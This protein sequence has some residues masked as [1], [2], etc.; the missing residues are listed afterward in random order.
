MS[1][2]ASA[3]LIH[4]SRHNDYDEAVR[5]LDCG[6]NLHADDGRGP[7]APL[8]AAASAGARSVV[9]LLLSRRTEVNARAAAGDTALSIACGRGRGQVAEALLEAG[10]STG[11]D[12]QGLTP[13]ALA[14]RRGEPALVALLLGGARRRRRSSGPYTT[15]SKAHAGGLFLAGD[16][17]ARRARGCWPIR[18]GRRAARGRRRARRDAARCAAAAALPSS[19]CAARPDLPTRWRGASRGAARGG[20]GGGGRQLRAVM[21]QEAAAAGRAARDAAAAA[22]R[23]AG[24]RTRYHR[25]RRRKDNARRRRICAGAGGGG[26]AGGSKEEKARAE[27]RRTANAAGRDRCGDRALP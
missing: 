26:G 10:A 23:G 22:R 20:G 25:W 11:R 15:G 17:A 6:A 5:L 8:R 14:A 12:A 16:T 13:L 1:R 24:A 19:T 9:D 7:G 27:R 4:A 18:D 2:Q 21:R 3:L